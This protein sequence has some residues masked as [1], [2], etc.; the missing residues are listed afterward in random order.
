MYLPRPCIDCSAITKAGKSRCSSCER[1]SRKVWD[2]GSVDNR[3]RR[4][5]SG[6]GAQRRLRYSLN[7]A[8]VFS[9]STCGGGYPPSGLRVD[10]RVPLASGGMDTD[11]NVQVLCVP[12]H[13]TKTMKEQRRA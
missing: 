7:K 9:C 11:E 2:K 12:C 5:Q 13:K 1:V 3:K 8:V 4:L 10:H 6:N